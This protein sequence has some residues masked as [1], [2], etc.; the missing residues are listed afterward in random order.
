MFLSF[1]YSVNE[2]PEGYAITIDKRFMDEAAAVV[3]HLPTLPPSLFTDGGVGKRSGQVWVAWYME[4]EANYPQMDNP[5]FM[6][7][8][9]PRMSH[10]LDADIFSPYL[11]RDFAELSSKPVPEKEPGKIP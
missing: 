10:R 5:E 1:I 6:S 4:C 11:P 8:F 9:D 2:L 7:R 3:F